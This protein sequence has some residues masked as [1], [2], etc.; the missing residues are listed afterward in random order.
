[1][2]KHKQILKNLRKIMNKK[3][4][5]KKS[6]K[7]LLRI[8]INNQVINKQLFN[9]YRMIQINRE[10]LFLRNNVNLKNQKINIKQ[11]SH[12]LQIKEKLLQYSKKYQMIK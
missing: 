1:M 12:G 6:I 3:Y 9:H 7:K 11:K 10:C 2:N 5:R 4:K 8:S